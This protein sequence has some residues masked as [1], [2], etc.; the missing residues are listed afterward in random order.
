[1][2]RVKTFRT[3]FCASVWVCMLLI[4][5]IGCTNKKN[6]TIANDSPESGTIQISVDEAFEPVITE[7]IKVYEAIHPGTK[8]I[9]H[10]KSEAD[11]L[12][13]FFND[14]SNRMT[15]VT[16]GLSVKESRFLNDSL[17]YVPSSDEIATDAVT[18]V[19]NKANIDTIFSLEKLQRLLTGKEKTSSK[20]V[21]DGLNA[22]STV[23][24]VMDS[25][26]KGQKFDTSVAQAVKNSK[27]V[28]DYIAQNPTAI[29][30]V[31][32][33]WIG[34]PEIKEQVE[35]LKKIKIAYIKC[36]AC[37][38]TPFVKPTQR[39][40]LSRRYPLVRHL[41]YILKENWN[42]LGSGFVNFLKY[43]KGQ[44]VFRRAYLGPVMNFD[45]RNVRINEKL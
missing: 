25:I 30:F 11:C 21:F 40:I 43:E 8:I 23:R 6:G 16:R 24:F 27:E 20:V 33:S 45:V 17:G 26:L 4:A 15:I 2:Y 7:Q 14:T 44:L 36:Q 31:G 41:Y 9:A 10:Y 42:G 34:N 29:G 19:V 12:K 38:D 28:L 22:T 39:G 13:D 5:L 35:M 18:I 1:M 37:T 3:A 32:F